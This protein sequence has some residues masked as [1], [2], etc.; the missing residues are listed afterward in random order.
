VKYLSLF[1]K[2]IPILQKYTIFSI[3][4]KKPPKFPPKGHFLRIVV[5]VMAYFAENS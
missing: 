3:K 4:N 5:E 2:K 1:L